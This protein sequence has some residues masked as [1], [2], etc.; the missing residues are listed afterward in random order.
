MSWYAASLIFVFRVR[1]GKQEHFPVWENVY[2]IEARSDHDAWKKAEELGRTERIDDES[3]TVDDQPA[4]LQFGGVRKLVTIQNPFPASPNAEVP[5]DRSE[6]TYSTFTLNSEEDL[7][8]LV[9]GGSVT[10]VYEEENRR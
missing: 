8:Q 10:L 9:T 6:I 7:K 3:L 1:K 4:S 2:L 5:S